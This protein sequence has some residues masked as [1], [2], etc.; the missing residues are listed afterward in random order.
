[1]N[2][3]NLPNMAGQRQDLIDQLRA[4][5]AAAKAQIQHETQSRESA[6]ALLEAQ[7]DL[8]TKL[9]DDLAAARDEIFRLLNS[10]G[11][12]ARK[13]KARQAAAKAENERQRE[14]LSLEKQLTATL[15]ET[16]AQIEQQRDNLL[17]EREERVET[18]YKVKWQNDHWIETTDPVILHEAKQYGWDM[19]QLTRSRPVLAVPEWLPIETAPKDGTDVLLYFPH[20]DACIRGRWDWQGEGD[21][22]SGIADWKDWCVDND[23]VIMEDLSYC[24]THWMPLP[25]APQNGKEK[26]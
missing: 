1:M 19:L 8:S 23:F 10:R 14:L 18:Y 22:E 7:I 9:S 17:A 24:P 16:I 20:I 12:F 15:Y 21:W 3:T 2:G 4:E 25:A 6:E 26:E 11:N 13:V 5:L